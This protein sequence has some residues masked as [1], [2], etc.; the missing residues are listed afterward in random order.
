VKKKNVADKLI[1]LKPE[2]QEASLEHDALRRVVAAIGHP[3][4]V[5]AYE[6]AQVRPA[7]KGNYALNAEREAERD[8]ANARRHAAAAAEAAARDEQIRTHDAEVRAAVVTKR[9]AKGAR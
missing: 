6:K 7:L 8:A 4:S 3:E 5:L 1:A 2:L 9:T